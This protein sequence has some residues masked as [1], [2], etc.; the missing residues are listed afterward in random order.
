MKKCL[1][2]TVFFLVT[3]MSFANVVKDK[4]YTVVDNGAIVSLQKTIDTFTTE[5]S[6]DDSCSASCYGD[7]YFNGVYRTTVF[8]SATA[9]DCV[10][11]Q[12]NCL[13]EANAKAQTYIAEAEISM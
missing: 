1:F 5:E 4:L 12:T 9:G 11:A 6:I 7:I 8:A 2:L 10:T 3:A 13:Q